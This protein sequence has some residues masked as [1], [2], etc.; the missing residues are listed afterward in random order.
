VRFNSFEK[1]I[2]R[3]KSVNCFS[4]INLLNFSVFLKHQSIE[5]KNQS[6][7]FLLFSNQNAIQRLCAFCDIRT[8]W[9]IICDFLREENMHKPWELVLHD[10]I[11]KNIKNLNLGAL[12]WVIFVLPWFCTKAKSSTLFCICFIICFC[13]EAFSF[14][15]LLYCEWFGFEIA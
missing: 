5:S 10:Y 9:L 8:I 11:K 13:I 2:L 7:E 3:E 4:E 6:I 12:L 14:S 1:P 15:L